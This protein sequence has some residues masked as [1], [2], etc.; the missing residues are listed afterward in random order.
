MKRKIRI[1]KRKKTAFFSGILSACMLMSALPV[2]VLAEDA[3]ADMGLTLTESG[4]L[5]EQGF[6]VMLYQTSFD[7]T[8]GDQHCAALE[9]ILDVYKRQGWIWRR[10]IPYLRTD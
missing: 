1:S 7:Q 9:L 2:N 3:A 4:Y 10:N 5:S 6:D 8:F